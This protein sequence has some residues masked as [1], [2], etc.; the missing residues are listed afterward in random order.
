MTTQASVLAPDRRTARMHSLHQLR[1]SRCELRASRSRRP[2]YVRKSR[3]KE[4]VTRVTVQ[5]TGPCF[6]LR[7]RPVVFQ[8]PPVRA[9]LAS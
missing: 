2:T 9:M 4:S 5:G 1:P 8:S 7:P 6:C 3:M